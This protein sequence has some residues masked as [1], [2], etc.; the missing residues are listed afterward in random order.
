MEFKM[1]MITAQSKDAI[2]AYEL[3][4][5]LQDRFVSKLND[6]SMSL[7]ENKNFEEI[8]WL[9]DEGI[10]G[11]GSRFEARDEK[12]FNAA[13]VNISQVHYDDMP[14]KNLQSASALSTI[15]HPKNPHV[16]SIHIHISL[17][18]LRDGSSYWRLMADLNPSIFNEE[19]KLTF[20]KILQK[21]TGKNYE[22]GT[23][24]G[25]KYF[26]IPALG[27]HRGVSHF[28]LENFRTGDKAQDFNFAKKFGE[29][30][31]DT[32]IKIITSALNTRLS[33]SSIP[34][35]FFKS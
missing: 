23:Q 31:I 32:Y 8:T 28:Y 10:H 19:D 33:C 30:V 18:E 7:G 27:R 3:V 22:E 29:S 4:K 24:Q 9:R 17:T 5:G 21:V 16:P 26:E 2:Q 25:D 20:D 1:N 13:S 14:K 6:L 34:S 15:I 35:T 12:I 11:G